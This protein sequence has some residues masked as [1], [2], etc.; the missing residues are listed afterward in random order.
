MTTDRSCAYAR[1]TKTV[2]DLGPAKLHDLEQRRV[3]NAADALLFAG[4]HDLEALAALDDIE[5]L[6]QE[7]ISCGRWTPQR[8]GRLADD[9]A[10]C[11]PACVY[12]RIAS[13]AA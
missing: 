11:G 6:M 3:R 9:V 12:G 7:L 2:A 13:R 10:A 5:Q 4:A 1:V 8:A